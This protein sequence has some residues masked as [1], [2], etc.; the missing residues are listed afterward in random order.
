M[1]KFR[2]IGWIVALG[3]GLGVCAG[4]TAYFDSAEREWITRYWSAPHRYTIQPD[5]DAGSGPWRVALTPEGSEWLWKY[6]RARGYTKV[7]P[8]AIPRPRNDTEAQWE[9]WIERKLEADR[10]SAQQE[11]D[12]RNNIRREADA[13]PS[14]IPALPDSLLALAGKPPAFAAAVRSQVYTV[15]FGPDETYVYK[16][17]VPMRPRYAYFRFGN[18]VMKGGTS[19][20]SLGSETLARLFGKAKISETE[21]R[22]MQAVSLLE[23]GFAAVNTYDTGFVSVGFIQF[24]CLRDGAGS[25]GELLLTM[26][27]WDPRAF[28]VDF[29][30]FGID[31]SDERKIVVFDCQKQKELI[32]ADAARKIIDDKRL[33]AVFQRAGELSEV[34]QVCQ[35]RVAK[36]RYYPSEQIV[37]LLIAGQELKVRVG[38]FVRSEAGMATLFDRKVNTGNIEPLAAVC[39]KLAKENAISSVKELSQFEY[40][41]IRSLRWRADYLGSA[42]LQK[43][44]M[45]DSDVSRAGRRKP[46]NPPPK[47]RLD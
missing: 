31:V 13:G 44:R 3:S 18:G 6:N 10:A 21:Q 37:Q 1:L 22:V 17:Q 30:R 16:D 2:A 40:E 8:G 36:D 7:A 24:A 12:Q 45:T 38:D 34:F 42:E 14:E 29:R 19:V 23:G 41:I 39:N 26:K 46:K 4:P 25:L 9:A 47:S 15:R 27:R 33:T 5:V 35:L 28:D 20:R 11:A 32:G 43:P